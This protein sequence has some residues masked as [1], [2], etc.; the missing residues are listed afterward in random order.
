[1]K[2]IFA[3]I[4]S[5]KNIRELGIPFSDEYNMVFERGKLCINKSGIEQIKDRLYKGN[6]IKDLHIIVGRTGAGKTNILQLIGMEEK[7]RLLSQPTDAYFLL[8][9]C[10]ASEE[11]FAVEVHNMF[12]PQ[13]NK[14][15]FMRSPKEQSIKGYNFFR[16]RYNYENDT[17]LGIEEINEQMWEDTA[18][19][20]TFDRNAFARYPYHDVVESEYNLWLPRKVTPYAE[21]FPGKVVNAAKE[22]VEQMPKESIKRRASFIINRENWQ[23][24]LNIV[25]DKNLL[26]KEYWLYGERRQGGIVTSLSDIPYASLSGYLPK[27]KSGGKTSNKEKFIHDLLT[28]FAIYLR[29]VAATV[30]TLSKQLSR[31]RPLQKIDESD[32]TILPDGREDMTLEQ[33]LSWLG[34]YIDYHT[35]ESLGNKGLVWQETKE[36]CDVAVILRQF[37]DCYFTPDQFLYPVIEINDED[38]RFRDLFEMMGQYHRDQYEVFP[39]EFLPYEL[40]YLS[41]GEF[42]Y[43]KIWGAIEEAIETKRAYGYNKGLPKEI[44]EQQLIV[45][46]DEPETYLH[47]EYCRE[48]IYRLTQVLSQR[49]PDL[50]LQLILTTHSPFMLSDTLSSQVTRVDYDEDGECIIYEDSEKQY[51]AANIFFIM[52]D[53][54]FLDYTIGE[55]ARTFLTEKFRFL[56]ALTEKFPEEITPNE[57]EKV[58]QIKD[59]IPYIGDEMIRHS[60]EMLLKILNYA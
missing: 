17:I 2:L 11:L 38:K 36:I 3:Y 22:Y 39:K 8:Y 6:L 42:Q 33:R 24:K 51:F 5:F 32:P 58:K 37:D 30:D 28:D 46:M 19:I 34:Q 57:R 29:K 9:K 50:Q 43:A 15:K 53:G 20:N 40:S 41:S 14:I 48:F 12:I 27:G 59:I 35:D 49:R 60:F 10:S 31:Y 45:L 23:H 4:K 21:T 16:F 25:L 26:D 18:I 1:M 55:Y 13:I 7:E 44:R 52:A 47:P 56:K 54:F